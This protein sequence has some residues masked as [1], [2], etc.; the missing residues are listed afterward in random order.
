MRIQHVGLALLILLSSC[1]IKPLIII[2]PRKQTRPTY[3]GIVHVTATRNPP[4]GAILI[5]RFEISV[6]HNI[7]KVI[8]AM[9]ERAAEIGGNL[10]VLDSV[11]TAYGFDQNN[12][13]RR[14]TN[15]AA[16]VFIAK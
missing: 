7:D 13:L 11:E 15:V 9:Q 4:E 1:G 6:I 3:E 8:P 12:Y 10:L 2:Q 5:A 14:H 16:R